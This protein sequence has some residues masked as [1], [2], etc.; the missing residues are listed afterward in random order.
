MLA[1]LLAIGLHILVVR[2][3]PFPEVD[4]VGFRVPAL[5]VRLAPSLAPRDSDPVPISAQE[6]RPT[7]SYS[8]RG[9][10]PTQTRKNRSEITPYTVE[11]V[12]PEPTTPAAPTPSISTEALVD[13]VRNIVRDE[14][15][16]TQ[17]SKKEDS[18]DI[19]DRPVLPE[20][21]KALQK[22]KASETRLADGVIKIVTPSGSTY[23]LKPLPEVV[24]RGGPVE[25]ATV[26]TNCP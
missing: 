4:S 15:R 8:A 14:E 23:C 9:T 17:Q 24:A 2:F 25:P 6:T 20:F 18:V 12:S 5:E 16:R 26:P 22:P 19:R 13:S 21:A 10:S 1:M 7:T 11:S 3:L